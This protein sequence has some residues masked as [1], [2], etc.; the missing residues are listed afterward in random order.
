MGIKIYDTQ[1]YKGL[2]LLTK[3]DSIQAE[4]LL[5]EA[6]SNVEKGFTINEGDSLYKVYPYQVNWR[7]Y[8][9][10]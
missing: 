8:I 5:S 4:L 1:Y 2:C 10:I 3:G 7:L 9:I 6:K